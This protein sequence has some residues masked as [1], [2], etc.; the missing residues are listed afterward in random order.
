VLSI[1]NLG[2]PE[3][4]GKRKSVFLSGIINEI[5]FV[6]CDP[7]LLL[8]GSMQG[9]SRGKSFIL[10]VVAILTLPTFLIAS[11]TTV[12][13]SLARRAG[14]PGSVGLGLGLGDPTG[15]DF[16]WMAQQNQWLHLE[17]GT[18]DRALVVYGDYHF[19]LARV[20]FREANL[21]MPISVGVGLIM[22][23]GGEGPFGKDSGPMFG[24]RV[25][26]NT[27]LWFERIPLAIFLELAPQVTTIFPRGFL[28]FQLGIRFYMGGGK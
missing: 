24:F 21:S 27:E 12:E 22:G 7:L 8:E 6:L 13:A 15:I 25:P 10:A 18:G 9:Y 19:A 5:L 2:V 14:S 16:V 17:L 28:S 23:A 1:A 26:L 11:E 3:F 4:L 20:M